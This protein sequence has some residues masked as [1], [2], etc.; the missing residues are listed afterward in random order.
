MLFFIWVFINM[1]LER[2]L[3]FRDD[4]GGFFVEVFLICVDVELR[5]GVIIWL[6]FFFGV[7]LFFW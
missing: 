4:V 5:V 2:K 7:K 3:W 1:E 6:V